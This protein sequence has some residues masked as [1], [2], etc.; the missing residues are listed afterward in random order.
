[1]LRKR[2][3]S[4]SGKRKDPLTYASASLFTIP[5]SVSVPCSVVTSDGGAAIAACTSSVITR[6][7][8]AV[9]DKSRLTSVRQYIDLFIVVGSQNVLSS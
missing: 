8:I 4:P 2:I 3:P 6:A 1:M 9:L 5:S 7:F